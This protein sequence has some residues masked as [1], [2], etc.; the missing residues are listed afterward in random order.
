MLPGLGI[1]QNLNG[2]SWSIGVEFV[3][4][5]VF[6]LLIAAAFGRAVIAAAAVIAAVAALVFVAA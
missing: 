3:A 2:P 1:G 6:P 5:L 4:Y